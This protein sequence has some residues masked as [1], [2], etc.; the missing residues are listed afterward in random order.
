[1]YDHSYDTGDDIDDDHIQVELC[2]PDNGERTDDL[3][4]NNE[5]KEM[6][7]IAELL[8]NELRRQIRT[9]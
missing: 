9:I 6:E 7:S 1:M 2:F 4:C 5:R 8:L 3:T